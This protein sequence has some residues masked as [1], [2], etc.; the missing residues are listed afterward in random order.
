VAVP[1]EEGRPLVVVVAVVA[2]DG[3]EATVLDQTKPLRF[4]PLVPPDF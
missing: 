1:S 3:I 4:F 2:A